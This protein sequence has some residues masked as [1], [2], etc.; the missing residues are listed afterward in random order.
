MAALIVSVAPLNFELLLHG[1]GEVARDGGS[2]RGR[3]EKR[4][5]PERPKDRTDKV[6]Q[7]DRGHTT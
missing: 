2:C 5:T 4:E 1:A 3:R 6:E 7:S